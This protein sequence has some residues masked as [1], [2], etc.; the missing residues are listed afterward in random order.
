MTRK[1]A[2]GGGSTKLRSGVFRA[3]RHRNFRLYIAGMAVSL[4]GTWMQQ[5]AQSWLVYRLTQSEWILGLT[6]FCANIP[7]L[8]LGPIGGL[9]ADRFPRRRI[10][11]AAQAAAMLQAVVLAALTLTGS[12]QVW[13]V[14]VLASVLGIANAFD[15]PGRQSLFVRLVGKEDLLNAI[16]LN[17]ATFNTARVVGPSLAGFLVAR[18]G[19]GFCFSLNAFSFIAVLGS[20]FAMDVVEEPAPPSKESSWQ[21]LRSGIALAW[22][23]PPLR[24]VLI[25]C[26]AVSLSVAPAMTLAPMFA[27][28]LFHRGAQ[29]LGLL[30]GGMGIGAILGTLSLARRRAAKGLPEVILMSAGTLAASMT[31]FA[32]SP[33]YW[34]CLAMMP[35]IGMGVM[36]HNAATNTTIQLRVP[37]EFRGRVMSL[38]SMMVIGMFPIG[39]LLSGA[40]A[41]QFGSRVT[42][43]IGALACLLAGLKVYRDRGTWTAWLAE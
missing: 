7:V 5:L 34:L 32:W 36:R 30:T 15:I 39:S 14:L 9:A 28:G 43:F 17:S 3:L 33:S 24:S 21:Q 27:D 29:G 12:V 23:T 13:H 37:D 25:V 4:S 35:L 11:M 8:V 2:R 20:L 18:L 26:G 19:E 42:V 6:W 40:L 22:N 16:S 31:V 10:V 1:N 41:A 38:Y